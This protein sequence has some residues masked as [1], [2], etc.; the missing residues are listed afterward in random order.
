MELVVVALVVGLL[1]GGLAL[2]LRTS[3]RKTSPRA[4][5]TASPAP[6]PEGPPSG[7][8]V[9]PAQSAAAPVDAVPVAL[10]GLNLVRAQDL[11]GDRRAAI[12]SVFR[13]VPRPPRLL[14]HLLS[15]DFVQEASTAQLVDLIQAEPLFA[16]KVLAAVNAALYALSRPVTSIEQAVVY[17]GL[18]GVRS[19]CLQYILI[20]SFKADSPQR[21]RLLDTTWAA[22]A[23]ASELTRQLAQQTQLDDRGALVSA[24]VLSFL[25]RL[26]TESATPAGIL[27]RLP[28]RDLLA[29]LTAEQGTLG[30]CSAEVGR[31][32]MT[33]WGL[34]P[35]VIE[36]AVSIDTLL[37]KPAPDVA[38]PLRTHDARQALCYLSARLGE[39]LAHGELDDLTAF[40]LAADDS[41]ELHHVRQRL[42]HPA[43]TRLPKLLR[44]P[45]LAATLHRMAAGAARGARAAGTATTAS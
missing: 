44:Q 27:S 6:R 31:L 13:D 10:S 15:P 45:E 20:S 22:S 35:A 23:M 34:P 5:T 14:H 36:D 18:D 41:V 33:A 28:P 7:D 19:V 9:V 42:A 39:R 8:A 2:V 30:L 11:S 12:L 38:D 17:L 29:R 21:Q 26:A 16:A 25:G 4:R 3:T 40:D 43:L 1:A 32:L 37:L 24:V